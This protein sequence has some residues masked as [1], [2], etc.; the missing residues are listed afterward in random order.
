MRYPL[1]PRERT[2]IIVVSAIILLNIAWLCWVKTRTDDSAY[3]PVER[4]FAP[5]N[6]VENQE[7]VM[8]DRKA[9]SEDKFSRS[10]KTGES[11]MRKKRKKKTS[12][13]SEIV[14]TQDARDFLRDSIPT[15]HRR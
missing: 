2:G 3:H 10:K 13:P 12:M 1:T 11:K 7:K 4:V 8:S 15:D 5:Q 14:P 9:V 6:S